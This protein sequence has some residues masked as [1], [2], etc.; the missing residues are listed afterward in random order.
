MADCQHLRRIGDNYG[1]TCQ[2]CNKPLEGYGYNDWL[3]RVTRGIECIHVWSKI[4]VTLE[5][6]IYCETERDN[7]DYIKIHTNPLN[8]QD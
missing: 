8:L 5:R 2:D 1:I 6:C 4:T 3:G 7:P